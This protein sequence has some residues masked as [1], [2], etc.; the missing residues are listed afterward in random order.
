MRH[1]LLAGAA[2]ALLALLP[3][4]SPLAAQPAIAIVQNNYSYI[5]PSL[6]N[7]GIAPG[8]LFIIVGTGLADPGS[9]AS[10][11]QDPSK[12]LPLTLHGASVTV[13]VNGAIAP[14]ALYYATPTVIAAVLP[15]ITPLGTLAAVKVTYGGATSQPYNTN[16]AQSAFGFDTYYGSGSG[17]AA[18]TDNFTGQLITP[19]NSAQPSETIVFWGSGLG[20]D[21][22]NTDVSPPTDVPHDLNYISQLFI[23][24]VPVPIV[25]QG[26]SHYQGVDQI[27]VTLP[28]NV[29][30][31]CAVSVVAV[32]GAGSSAVVSNTVTIPISSNGGACSDSLQPIGAAEAATLAGDTL[33]KF[34]ALSLSQTTNTTGTSRLASAQFASIP[35]SSLFPYLGNTLPSLGSCVVY[36]Q[37]PVAPVNPFQLEGLNPGTVSVTGANGTQ[38]LSALSSGQGLYTAALTA[39]FLPPTAGAFTFNG[40]GGTDVQAFNAAL[41][42]PN[43]LN[44]TNSS[45]AG[46][47][48]RAQG[49]TVNWAPAGPDTYVQISGSATTVGATAFFVCDAPASPATFTVP[50]AILLALP[51]GG[52]GIEVSNFTTP[53]S[54]SATGLD[55]GYATSYVSVFVSTTYQ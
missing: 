16:V 52:G 1:H 4:V 35:G 39:G 45:A 21:T 28:P 13:T 11:L 29:P 14:C 49:L 41:D 27:D 40:L 55:F 8:S 48:T 31:G 32:S 10:P 24:G 22:N 47:I 3:A 15:S 34:G 54:F 43:P 5:L 20:A 42:F 9:Q 26:R 25:Y 38:A 51:A 12:A 2:A 6:P 23:G 46:A 37:G 53:K 19:S 33:V 18:V 44:W 30:T 50:P 17:M 7:Y 36:Q